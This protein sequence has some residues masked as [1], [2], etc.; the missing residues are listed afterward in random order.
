[1]LLGAFAAVGPVVGAMVFGAPAFCYG[2]V[3]GEGFAYCQR[4][5]DMALYAAGELEFCKPQLYGLFGVS[6]GELLIFCTP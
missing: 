5:C 6:A 3:D 1:M 2:L 4:D